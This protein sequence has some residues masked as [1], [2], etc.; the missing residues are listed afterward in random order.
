MSRYEVIVTKEARIKRI[1]QKRAK[2]CPQKGLFRKKKATE[3]LLFGPLWGVGGGVLN[4]VL[5]FR[6]RPRPGSYY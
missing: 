5:W 4:K 1:L 6:A 2:V 3:N